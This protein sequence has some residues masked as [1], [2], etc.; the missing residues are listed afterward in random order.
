MSDEDR[1][2][3]AKSRRG[4]KRP[5]AGRK[6]KG[7]QSPSVVSG[8]DLRAALSAAPPE[9]IETVAQ[10]HAREAIEALVR[11]LMYGSSEAARVTAANAILDRGYGKPSSDAAS[12]GQMSLFGAG[13]SVAVASGIRD[14]AR[15]YANLSI[16]VL[17]KI[18]SSGDSDSARVSA[19]RSLL[20][21]GVGAVATAKIQD[22]AAFKP[23]GKKEEQAAA[24]QAA[25]T[26]RFATPA[27]PKMITGTV[28]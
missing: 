14:E 8:V 20:D 9:D 19:A 17:R 12:F 21:R 28:Q 10:R 5:G 1:S 13:I 18:A 3:N 2:E 4:G 23:M 22:N 26:G 24:A 16:E 6:K 15:K 27:P 25:G 11:Q 7:H